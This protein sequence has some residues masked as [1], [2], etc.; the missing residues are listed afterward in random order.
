[1]SEGQQ[2]GDM[3]AVN[4]STAPVVTGSV[5]G[6]TVPNS[7]ILAAPAYDIR[8]MPFRISK[9]DAEEPIVYIKFS[10]IFKLKFPSGKELYVSKYFPYNYPYIVDY[11]KR[12]EKDITLGIDHTVSNVSDYLKM[13]NLLLDKDDLMGLALI[14]YRI[15]DITSKQEVDAEL[16]GIVVED[17]NR[18]TTAYIYNNI[19]EYK[20]RVNWFSKRPVIELHTEE[21]TLSY[22]ENNTIY[23]TDTPIDFTSLLDEHGVGKMEKML[24]KLKEDFNG[25]EYPLINLLKPSDD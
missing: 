4:T 7:I 6:I 20:E 5:S 18:D 3:V 25:E 8:S 11:L 12:I 19:E 10:V 22:I 14:P 9:E 2:G 21:L 15:K 23:V 16:V 17:D 24:E 1:M 13:V